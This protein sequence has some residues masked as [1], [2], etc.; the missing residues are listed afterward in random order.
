MGGLGHGPGLGCAGRAG[1]CAP[2]RFLSFERRFRRRI[3]EGV[4][5]MSKQKQ[6]GFVTMGATAG[7]KKIKEIGI[8]M[9]GYAFMG[10]AHSDAYR[11]TQSISGP[12][13]RMPRRGAIG[14]RNE[15]AV[16]EAARRY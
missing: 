6:G 9:P 4:D 11:K 14:G 8:G 3:Q 13:P 12:P 10:Q 15:P 5:A 16:A 2:D 7:G 1:P